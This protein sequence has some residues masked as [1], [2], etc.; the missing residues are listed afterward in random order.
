MTFTDFLW[1]AWA[2]PLVLSLFL[3][4]NLF[5][6]SLL[7]RTGSEA[8]DEFVDAILNERYLCCAFLIGSLIPLVNMMEVILFGLGH[9]YIIGNYIYERRPRQSSYGKS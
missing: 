3:I 1:A 7:L 8:A 4:I 6:V 5:L 2:V 9:I